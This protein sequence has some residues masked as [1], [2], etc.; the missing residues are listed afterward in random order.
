M[1]A[2][3]L[4]TACQS[5]KTER[6]GVVTRPWASRIDVKYPSLPEDCFCVHSTCSAGP[7]QARVGS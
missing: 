4:V 7:N 5:G 1:S 3:F 2:G 6:L